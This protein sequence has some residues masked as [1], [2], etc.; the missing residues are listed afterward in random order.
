MKLDLEALVEALAVELAP[1]VAAE[2]TSLKDGEHEPVEEPWRLLNLEEAAARLGRS[3]RWVREQVK[4]GNLP[5]VRLDGAALA[6]DLD[7]LRA[8]AAARRIPAER[9]NPLA[10][11]LQGNGDRAPGAGS[12]GGHRLRKPRVGDG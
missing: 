6:F 9:V 11:R 4:R 3:P 5:R 7:D 10:V 8:F 12:S 2:L 1:R